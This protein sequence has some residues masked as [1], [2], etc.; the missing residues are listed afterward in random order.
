M[1][2]MFYTEMLNDLL[3]HSAAM[4]YNTCFLTN[5]PSNGINAGFAATVKLGQLFHSQAFFSAVL[6]EP[7]RAEAI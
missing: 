4:E 7:I 3:R 2:W 5:R 6:V 1:V